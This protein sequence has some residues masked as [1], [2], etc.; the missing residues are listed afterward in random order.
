MK[1]EAYT[2]PIL[3]GHFLR[4]EDLSLIKKYI[5]E[6]TV[7]DFVENHLHFINNWA[8]IKHPV[9]KRIYRGWS[10]AKSQNFLKEFIENQLLRILTSH[11]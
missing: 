2:I 1:I 3:V 5:E 4:E 11:P 7:N 8:E 6:N 10:E 9:V